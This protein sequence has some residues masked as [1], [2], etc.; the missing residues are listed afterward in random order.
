M[1]REDAWRRA[2]GYLYDALNGEEADEIIKALEEDATIDEHY[3]KGFNNGIRTEKFRESKR[4]ELCTEIKTMT[5][6]Q[7]YMRGYKDGKSDVLDEVR[8]EIEA[9]EEGIM[10]Y[11]NDRP[12]I[13]KDEV[14]EIIGKY[15]GERKKSVTVAK[16]HDFYPEDPA[17]WPP[18]DK[19]ILVKN[20]I[21]NNFIAYLGYDDGEDGGW[22]FYSEDG[23]FIADVDEIDAWMPIPQH[24]RDKNY[25]PVWEREKKTISA[26]THDNMEEEKD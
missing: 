10:S 14:L 4:Q 24:E 13:F 8:A 11:H 22:G 17:T 19:E 2:K 16:F 20:N 21:G 5:K 15:K 9:L 6:E 26:E 18:A 3:W 12:W 7:D 1:T 25:I 23:D